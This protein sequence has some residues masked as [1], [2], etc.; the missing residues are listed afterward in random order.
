MYRKVVGNAPFEKGE[1]DTNPERVWTGN[2]CCS[3]NF[4]YVVSVTSRR[5]GEINEL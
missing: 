3:F 2:T 1:Y 5:I 4:S